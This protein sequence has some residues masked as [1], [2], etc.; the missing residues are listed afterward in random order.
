M[1]SKDPNSPPSRKS[2]NDPNLYVYVKPQ[3]SNSRRQVPQQIMKALGHPLT[4]LVF[5]PNY[6]FR[7]DLRTDI[8]NKEILIQVDEEEKT[9]V[10]SK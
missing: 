1:V 2:G 6:K 10:N 8:M 7:R 3:T 4:R 5:K 9:Q